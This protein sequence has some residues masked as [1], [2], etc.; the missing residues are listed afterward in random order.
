[1]P[2]S[3]IA[4]FKN[5]SLQ[6]HENKF[7]EIEVFDNSEFGFGELEKLIASQK[8]MGGDRLPVL[9]MCGEYTTTDVSFMN[10]LS[11]NENDPYSKADAFVINSIS[12]KI[13]ANF[14][15]KIARP[16]RPTKFFNTRDDAMKWLKQFI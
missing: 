13:M 1:M 12:Q 16:E 5:F 4:S 9:V 6:K 7:Y 11:K 14:Y 15:L 2:L 10:H 8:E 3:N